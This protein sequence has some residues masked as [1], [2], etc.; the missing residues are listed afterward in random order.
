[1]QEY[2]LHINS[3]H[4]SQVVLQQQMVL[5]SHT[6]P[7][8]EALHAWEDQVRFLGPPLFQNTKRFE[9]FHGPLKKVSQKSNHKDV[10][11]NIMDK[12]NHSYPSLCFSCADSNLVSIPADDCKRS[13]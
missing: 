1:M 7:K 13:T 10:A 12:V 8:L 3:R 5:L 6:Y 9:Q 11:Y 4:L 2:S